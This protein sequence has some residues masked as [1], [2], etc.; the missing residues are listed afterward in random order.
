ML[1]KILNIFELLVLFLIAN[2]VWKSYTGHFSHP[3][4][5]SE[6]IPIRILLDVLLGIA[7]FIRLGDLISNFNQKPLSLIKF[8]LPLLLYSIAIIPSIWKT[9]KISSYFQPILILTT[10]IGF[11]LPI[12]ILIGRI[13]FTK[14]QLKIETY[15]EDILDAN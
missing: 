2:A 4:F 9:I 3:F 11:F 8:Y 1:S 6:S 10:L 5:Y 12:F 7:I 14:R 15:S 13:T